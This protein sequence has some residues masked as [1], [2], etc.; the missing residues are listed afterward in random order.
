MGKLISIPLSLHSLNSEAHQTYVHCDRLPPTA[1]ACA[2]Q[3]P[4]ALSCLRAAHCARACA[5]RTPEPDY[6]TTPELTARLVGRVEVGPSPFLRREF[7]SGIFSRN[8]FYSFLFEI[9]R[10]SRP[11]RPAYAKVQRFTKLVARVL[12]LLFPNS[13]AWP[14]LGPA[15]LCF[16]IFLCTPVNLWHGMEARRCRRQGLFHVPRRQACRRES[17]QNTRGKRSRRRSFGWLRSRRRV[18]RLADRRLRRR[19]LYSMRRRREGAAGPSGKWDAP[20]NAER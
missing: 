9:L 13:S 6:Y 10:I 4:A 12:F 5:R 2:R 1:C 15:M 18:G 19:N 8:I 3:L 16:Q 7:L 20:A 14:R 11:C 17:G